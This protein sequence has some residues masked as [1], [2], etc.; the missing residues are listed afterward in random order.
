MISGGVHEA[1]AIIGA[2]GKQ[3]L[4]PRPPLPDGRD[5]GLGTGAVG[6]VGGGE[7]DHQKPSIRIHGDVTLAP[8][9]P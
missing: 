2:V 7:V 3:V 5:D 8:D 6:D 1:G 4:E 9:D